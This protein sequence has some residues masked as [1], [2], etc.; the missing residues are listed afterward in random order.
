MTLNIKS[1]AVS[2]TSFLH[3]K[4]AQENLMYTEP[5]KKG[6]EKLPVGVNVYGPGSKEYQAAQ[7]K[8]N[9]RAIQRLQKRGGKF[10]QT[11]EE[12]QKEQV[13]YLAE[14]THSFENLDYEGITSGREL[15]LAVYGDTSIGF[16]ADQVAEFVK[17]WSNFTQNS[18]KS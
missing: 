9:N 3:L 1:K 8:V 11:A 6:A 14:I 15:A 12:K 4:D 16:V 10:E 7:T 2:P 17:D 5:D 13:H 18:V